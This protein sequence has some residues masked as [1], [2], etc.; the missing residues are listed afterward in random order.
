[1]KRTGC[2]VQEASNKRVKY[3]NE[4][5][6]S[7]E[8][9][10]IL[11]DP[12]RLLYATDLKDLVEATGYI[13]G[14][15]IM[16]WPHHKKQHILLEIMESSVGD[17]LVRVDVYFQGKCAEEL[18]ERDT[19]LE[20]HDEIVLGL[21]GVTVEKKA[22]ASSTSFGFMLRYS[23]GV[24]LEFVKR[25]H[26]H[27]PCGIVDSWTHW[28]ELP[29]ETRED[30]THQNRA[31]LARIPVLAPRNEEE[32]D[33][34]TTTPAP[35][36]IEI[37]S[38]SFEP[39]IEQISATAVDHSRPQGSHAPLPET[40]AGDSP[41][42]TAKQ[43][44]KK[45]YLAPAPETR[46]A[47][48]SNGQQPPAPLAAQSAEERAPS[49]GPQGPVAPSKKQI[50]RRIKKE[51]QKREREEERERLAALESGKDKPQVSTSSAPAETRDTP[52]VHAPIERVVPV[53]QVPVG[54]LDMKAGRKTRYVTFPPLADA[55]SL[56]TVAGVVTNATPI[57]A[58]RSGE[59]S[60]TLG[61]VDPSNCKKE[62]DTY[63]DPHRASMKVICFAKKEGYLLPQP[64]PGDV[65]ILADV[66]ASEWHG[67]VN[68][69]GS[70]FKLRWAIY[71]P[72]EGRIHHGAAGEAGLGGSGPYNPFY[73]VRDE[74]EVRYCGELAKWW[75][76]IEEEQQSF[77]SRI[78]HLGG[79]ESHQLGP[80]IIRSGRPNWVIKD[81]HP[82]GESNGYFNATVEVVH[83]YKPD[84][85]PYYCLYVT[86]YTENDALDKFINE[87]VH[88]SLSQSIARLEC[89]DKSANVAAQMEVG[90]F[91]SLNN[92]RCRMNNNGTYELKMQ[93]P[94]LR[95]LSE[96]DA[97]YDKAFAGLLERKKAH[98]EKYGTNDPSEIEHRSVQD[99]V[100]GK[101]FSAVVELIHREPF[102]SESKKLVLY[103]TDY[104]TN[105]FLSGTKLPAGIPPSLDG[106]VLK[107]ALYDAHVQLSKHLKV[108]D[109]VSVRRMR[110]TKNHTDGMSAK[111]GG[112]EHLLKR[113]VP[114]T[115]AHKDLIAG[116]R[117]NKETWKNLC[118][119][120]LS[121]G[122]EP[123]RG[124]PAQGPL[125]PTTPSTED[126]LPLAGSLKSKSGESSAAASGRPRCTPIDEVQKVEVCPA[127]FRIR[128]RVADFY[129]SV[130]QFVYSR[131]RKCYR[132]LS[133]TERACR[134]CND[135]DHEYVDFKYRFWLVLEDEKGTQLDV[136]VID[137]CP[138]LSGFPRVDL[139][140]DPEAH[141]KVRERLR[142]LTGNV[143]A[144]VVNNEKG[145]DTK[146][147]SPYLFC[148][149]TSYLNAE[150]EKLYGLH[151]VDA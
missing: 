74:G 36:R 20:V 23:D 22:Q 60:C 66:K 90:H 48:A 3:A 29:Q 55:K 88:V 106:K 99:A 28:F 72:E 39:S 84:S 69:I 68:L 1:M 11:H 98:E 81:M 144:Y 129:P 82:G 4:S 67:G 17:R 37:K 93:E 112:E 130:N 111:L 9:T 5:S 110:I 33:P 73:K 80:P 53:E 151:S 89:W 126:N 12:T 13:R 19:Y 42:Q 147:D 104:T 25:R 139:S 41:A 14:K 27:Q 119:P 30:V 70:N 140:E 92:V 6:N 61:I 46:V 123:Q 95:L 103:V 65:V 26:A 18:A 77:N 134:E 125:T 91:I 24:T 79:E 52:P 43:N 120:T 15:I 7:S 127:K 109:F 121:T 86:D 45:P 132:E 149:V 35:D 113:L 75:K 8:I 21:R 100:E 96:I 56:C 102:T 76:A 50:K 49:L 59:L 38:E 133:E 85:Q 118:R 117:R 94:K 105:P 108:G 97:K 148:I 150:K 63:R 136:S 83:C 131:C 141:E 138:I 142:A 101:H 135:T 143:E 137:D 10:S 87:G 78:I 116:L 71:S 16:R 62:D 114:G 146:L 32:L 54:P 145:Q 107:L 124:L 128:A 115:D 58:T 64:Q 40:A 31:Q 34:T 57:N 122:A 44:A 2:D 51:R 47:Q